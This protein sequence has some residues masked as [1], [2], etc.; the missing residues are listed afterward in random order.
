MI[1]VCS[2]R[3]GV[4]QQVVMRSTQGKQRKLLEGSVLECACGY[5]CLCALSMCPD[6]ARAL[7]QRRPGT[8]YTQDY[9]RAMVNQKL[10]YQFCAAYLI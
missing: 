8:P 9:N 6:M 4:M 10:H 2:G 5:F 3:L 1:R 7:R